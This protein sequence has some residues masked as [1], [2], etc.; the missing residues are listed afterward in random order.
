M[1]CGREKAELSKSGYVPQH[2]LLPQ[3]L[4]MAGTFAGIEVVVEIF[5]ATFASKLA[6]HVTS[7]TGTRVFNRVTGSVFV[8]AGAYLMTLERPR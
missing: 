5:L 7:G 6:A 8:L 2:G 1:T 4:V 3:F